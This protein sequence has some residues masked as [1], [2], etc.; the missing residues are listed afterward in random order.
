MTDA[1]GADRAPLRETGVR[2]AVG[3]PIIVEGRLWGVMAAGSTPG[4]AAAGGHRGA[5]AAVHRACGDR[6]RQHRGPR[7]VARLAE[8]QAALRRVATLVARGAPP[9]E[10]F[11]AV[12]EE[13]GRL[14]G[15][16]HGDDPLRE[17]RHGHARRQRRRPARTRLG[18]RWPLRGDE[19][20][21]ARAQTGRPAR[22]D[23]YADA[24]ARSRTRPPRGGHPLRGR[25]ADRRRGAPVGRAGR[26]LADGQPLRRTPSRARAASRSWSATADREH[27]GPRGGGRLADE[28]AAL[29][30]VATLV[31][32]EPP[33][34]RG[35]RGGGARGR[36][37]L[38]RRRHAHGPLRRRGGDRSCA[39]WSRAER[40]PRC[41]HARRARRDANVASVV[42][43]HAAGRRGSTATAAATG[44]TADRLRQRM[45]VRSSVAVPIVVDGRLWGLMIASRSSSRRYRPTPSRRLAAFTELA[46]TAIAN[47]EAR[48][49]L[50]ASRARLRGRRRRGAP[51][52]RA[53][54]ARRRAAAPRPHDRHAEAGAAQALQAPRGRRRPAL[55]S[56]GARP[57]ASSAM[58]E[59]RELAHGILPTVLTTRRAARGSRGAGLADAR[60]GRDRR[61]RGPAASRGRGDR[62]LRRR[63]GADQRR[64]ARA[65]R[66]RATV[67]GARSRTARCTSRSA[68]TASAAPGPS[69]SG[70]VGLADRLAALDGRLRVESPAGGGTLV[71]ATIP[72]PRSGA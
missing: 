15:G 60:A 20:R 2:S 69:G 34:G 65:R 36:Q 45:G 3:A 5:A 62:V 63:R 71:A 11:A 25:D 44:P 13:V 58:D 26:P 52:R 53:R 72:L 35:L 9:E 42:F 67:H 48:A 51:A 56:G 47:A 50:A 28:Q 49:E 8:E 40:S 24:P 1:S 57:C 70:L 33:A 19:P 18:S 16:R 66:Q 12:A 27:R 7:R 46:E 22:I 29:R 59:L 64:Q 39:G 55:V 68:T 37:L 41:R 61:V 30:R 54:P 14:L 6:D 4:G 10:V 38:R 21:R 32:R 31:A 43:Q 23:N 17:R